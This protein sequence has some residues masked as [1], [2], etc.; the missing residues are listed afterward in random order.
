MNTTHVGRWHRRGGTLVIDLA[1]GAAPLANSFEEEVPITKGGAARDLKPA[2]DE[3]LALLK[4]MKSLGGWVDP[5][6]PDAQPFNDAF[7]S[8]LARAKRAAARYA[9]AA[10]AYTP[11]SRT[12]LVETRKLMA[13]FLEDMDALKERARI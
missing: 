9:K 2:R 4:E 5:S 8:A 3:L 11:A 10:G 12:S 6:N 7:A 1:P 13:E